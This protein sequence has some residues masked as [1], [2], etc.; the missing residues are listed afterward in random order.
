MDNDLPR[1]GIAEDFSSNA[2]SLAQRRFP[3]WY[4]NV[5]WNDDKWRV[6]KFYGSSVECELSRWT[7]ATKTEFA[8]LY[9]FSTR[10][11]CEDK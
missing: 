8:G 5:M 6:W 1:Y 11:P 4:R 10:N 2:A 7:M 9:E 3:L